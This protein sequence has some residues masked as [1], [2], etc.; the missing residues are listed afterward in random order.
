MK[1]GYKISI[2]IVSAVV[3]IAGIFW[4]SMPSEQRNMVSF[5]MLNGDSYDNYQEYQVIDRN[6]EA[7]APTSFEPGV[8]D[9]MEGDNNCNVVAITE[10]VKNESSKML[11]IGRMQTTGIDDYTGWHLIADEGAAEGENPY[12]PSPLSYYTS[13]L[14]ANLHTQ[15]LKAAEV[16][17]VELEN[18][19]V[20][21]LN[22]FRWNE[23]LS[24]EGAGFLDLTITNIIIESSAS[25]ELIREIKEMALNSWTAGEALR[26]ETVIEPSLVVNGDNWKNYRATPGTSLSAESFVDG[27]RIS[28]ISKVPKKPAYL[29]PVVKEAEE[30]VPDF[31]ALSNMEFE[32]FAISESAENSNRPYLKKITLSTPSPETWEIYSDEFMGA[33]DHPV[34]PTSLEYF[35]AG[36]A[37]C[38]TSQTTLVS[39]MMGLKFADYRVENQTDYRQE[40][41]NSTDMVGYTNAVHSYIVIESDES[42][43]RLETFYNKSLSLC[44]AG[45]GLKNAT[46]MNTHCYLNGKLVE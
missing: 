7:L 44:F 18:V 43:E 39:A 5:M 38:L 33:N 2:A 25:K 21:V 40:A 9:K 42:Q 10:M 13:G 46:E 30:G 29:E 35:T 8:A 22:K 45:E 17:G 15:I 36:T 24:A 37:L 27:L 16:I 28:S 3:V 32:I 31:E 19:K 14:A 12:G 23:M 34:A 11:K 4:F 1:K 6:D 20:E 41:I 26:N